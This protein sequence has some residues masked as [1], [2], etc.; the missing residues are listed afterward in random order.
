MIEMIEMPDPARPTRA[1]E[2]SHQDPTLISYHT[3]SRA[4]HYIYQVYRSMYLV[5]GTY[6]PRMILMSS[7]E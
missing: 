5:S 4:D 2:R 1:Q 7:D 6:P 3:I